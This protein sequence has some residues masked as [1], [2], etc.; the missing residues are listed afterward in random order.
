MPG[1]CFSLIL[2]SHLA[3][4]RTYALRL[5]FFD[6]SAVLARGG[7]GEGGLL[8]IEPGTTVDISGSHIYGTPQA[9]PGRAELQREQ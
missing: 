7:E 2:I 3:E 6:G 8:R 9:A 1:I 5:R 4:E